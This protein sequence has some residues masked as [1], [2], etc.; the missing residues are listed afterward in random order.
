MTD[1]YI[2]EIGIPRCDGLPA[3]QVIPIG[4]Y[5]RPTGD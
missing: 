4:I 5:P 1:P 2:D 3:C